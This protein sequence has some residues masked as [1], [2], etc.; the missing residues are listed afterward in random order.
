MLALCLWLAVIAW[1]VGRSLRPAHAD[2]LARAYARLCRK[3]ARIVPRAPHEGPLAFG[4]AVIARCPA[5]RT[6]L[7]PLLERYAELRYGP[8]L[9]DTRAADVEAFRRAVRRWSLPQLPP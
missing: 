2:P 4:A 7:L 9:P 6:S 3:L 1:H 8:P 5:A